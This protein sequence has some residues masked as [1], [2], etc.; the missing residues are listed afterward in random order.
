MPQTRASAVKLAPIGAHE[1][2]THSASL[3]RHTSATSAAA[4]ISVY[5]NKDIHAAGTWT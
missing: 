1:V 4:A 5:T 2:S 3:R